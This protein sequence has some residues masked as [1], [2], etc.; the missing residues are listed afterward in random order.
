MGGCFF[1]SLGTVRVFES[2]ARSKHNPGTRYRAMVKA[3]SKRRF[4]GNF[5]TTPRVAVASLLEKIKMDAREHAEILGSFDSSSV[6]APTMAMSPPTATTNSRGGNRGCDSLVHC[7]FRDNSKQASIRHVVRSSDK[8]IR[9]FLIRPNAERLY[10]NW[11]ET[12]QEA[13][14]FLAKKAMSQPC[15]AMSLETP[16]NFRKY[17]N[18]T[19][20]KIVP[21]L[22][23]VFRDGV[24]MSE[25][26]QSSAD[27]WK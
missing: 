6:P 18:A 24:P 5:R 15:G 20:V 9:M 22:Y 7:F 1:T 13:F 3:R 16:P 2:P 17:I 12:V 27:A 8:K 25:L 11:H 19:G 23:G 21:Q 14:A 26:F 10:S 4:A